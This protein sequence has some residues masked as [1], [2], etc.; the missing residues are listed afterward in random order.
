MFKLTLNKD[1]ED[2]LKMSVDHNNMIYAKLDL[3]G[4]NNNKN[5]NA[6]SIMEA[7]NKEKT[8]IISLSIEVGVWL[9]TNDILYIKNE[10]LEDLLDEIFLFLKGNHTSPLQH[11]TLAGIEYFSFIEEVTEEEIKQRKD[12]II[13]SLPNFLYCLPIETITSL[14]L[15]NGTRIVIKENIPYLLS[16]IKTLKNLQELNIPK[17]ISIEAAA[18]IKLLLKILSE[19]QIKK[20]DISSNPWG[21]NENAI[22]LE[23]FL[24]Q[25][26]FQELNLSNWFHYV[27]NFFSDEYELSDQQLASCIEKLNKKSLVKLIIN[28]RPLGPKSINALIKFF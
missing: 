14:T 10:S 24:K 8:R 23:N 17:C 5:V 25:S 16:F 12:N 28:D 19:K 21:S 11:I 26:T 4:N 13:N 27:K 15:I 18:N 3:S 20:L 6:E 9:D 7:L 2:Y 22:L 1:I